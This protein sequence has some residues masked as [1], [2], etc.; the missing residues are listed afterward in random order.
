VLVTAGAVG[1]HRWRSTPR[2]V[3]IASGT[4]E[5]TELH[6]GFKVSGQLIER[7]VDEG[8][9]AEAGA[10]IGR[11]ESRDLEAEAERLRQSSRATETQLPLAPHR[12]PPAGAAHGQLDQPGSREP[13]LRASST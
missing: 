8:S 9:R 1:W 5:A 6:L 7:P 12:H 13:S 10:L 2:D 11:L 4:I 3:L